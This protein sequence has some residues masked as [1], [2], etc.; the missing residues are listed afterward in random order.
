MELGV[1]FGW[2]QVHGVVYKMVMSL[3]K[4]PYFNNETKSAVRVPFSLFVLFSD[5]LFSP[6]GN[7]RHA[8]I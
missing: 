1:Y 7:P 5:R 4:N 6:P 2:A 8:Q 3:G